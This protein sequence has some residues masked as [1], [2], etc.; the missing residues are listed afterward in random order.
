MNCNNKHVK[1]YGTATAIFPEDMHGLATQYAFLDEQLHSNEQAILK[2][3]TG[4]LKRYGRVSL[5]LTKEEEAEDN[6][7]PVTTIL[8]GK[9]DTPHIKITDVYLLEDKYL[10]ADGIDADSGKKRTG[11]YIHSEQYADI[12]QFIGHASDMN[13]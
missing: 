4:F 13:S 7:F 9:H 2:F 8:Y 3:M 12:F 6:N 10:Y 5:G 1:Q 11:F